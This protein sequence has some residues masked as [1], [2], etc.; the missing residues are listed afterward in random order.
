MRSKPAHETALVDNGFLLAHWEEIE[1]MLASAFADSTFSPGFGAG[2]PAEHT[3]EEIH[4]PEGRGLRHVVAL[5]EGGR[6]IGAIF[7][8]RT[9]RPAHETTCDIGWFF[10]DS[11]RSALERFRITSALVDRAYDEL[12]KVGYEAV[13]TEMGTEGGAFILSR[14]HGFAPAPT[15]E[16]ANRWIKS[17][18]RVEEV[19]ISA[20]SAMRDWGR[21]EGQR[22]RCATVDIVKGDV[23]IDF[24]VL[25]KGAKGRSVDTV[26]LGEDLFYRSGAGPLAL[27]HHCSP[28]CR[29]RFEDLT[30]CALR[31]ISAG[32]DL[33][34][35]YCTT[36]Y[37][38]AQAFDCNCGSPDCVGR[39]TGFK[40]LDATQV[41]RILDL[42][43]PY[44]RSRL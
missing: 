24:K 11:T 15:A 25:L 29:I 8:L 26:Q 33:T 30:F 19:G 35:N 41:E 16:K 14:R 38:I 21:E 44:L 1:A 39:V 23:I 17:L 43:S 2:R 4:K 27:N 28:N 7:C 12:R 13:V 37:E 6:V 22:T 40:D 3:W 42:L 31:D 32:E 20:N 36:E 9:E 10:T 18:R 34:F 5:D